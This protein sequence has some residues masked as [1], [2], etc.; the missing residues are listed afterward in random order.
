MK[1]NMTFEFTITGGKARYFNAERFTDKDIKD[2]LIDKDC[3]AIKT[4][5]S[6]FNKAF[7][8]ELKDYIEKTVY[9]YLWSEE[10]GIAI[11]ENL[12]EVVTVK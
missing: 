4:S 1:I 9:N 2:Y 10:M 7:R 8:E 12:I 11:Q 3:I 5:K 6:E